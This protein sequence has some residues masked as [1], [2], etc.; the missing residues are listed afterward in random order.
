MALMVMGR[1]PPAVVIEY[2]TKVKQAPIVTRVS[3]LNLP[4]VDHTVFFKFEMFLFQFIVVCSFY[5]DHIKNRL[6]SD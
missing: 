3:Q 2:L 6:L 5:L 4:S 1:I